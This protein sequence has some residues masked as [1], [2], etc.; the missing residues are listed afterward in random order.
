MRIKIRAAIISGP[1]NT[2]T[3]VTLN[4]VYD[5]LSFVCASNGLVAVIIGDNGSLYTTT[6]SLESPYGNWQ[7]VSVT[8]G[9]SEQL[10]PPL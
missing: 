5:V 7:L 6:N 8:A 4:N 2:E 1:G 3:N 9:S 10:Y